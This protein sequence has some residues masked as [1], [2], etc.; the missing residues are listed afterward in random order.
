MPPTTFVKNSLPDASTAS[1]LR[2]TLSPARSPVPS[3]VITTCVHSPGGIRFRLLG[4]M[5]GDGRPGPSGSSSPVMRKESCRDPMVI[6]QPRDP[7]S[8]SYWPATT[9][10]P[11][12]SG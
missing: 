8:G 5:R 12:A 1:P 10:F 11:S 7:S 3:W 9:K 4:A 6:D 2:K